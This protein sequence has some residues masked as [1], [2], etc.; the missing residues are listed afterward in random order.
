MAI[1][2]TMTSPQIVHNSSVLFETAW[3][4]FR[5]WLASGWGICSVTCGEGRQ[6]RNIHCWQTLEA[7]FHSSVHSSLCASLV[8]PSSVRS[9]RQIDCGPLWE[10]SEWSQV[11]MERA[12]INYA[13]PLAVL[14][15]YFNT[16]RMSETHP[17]MNNPWSENS[18]KSPNCLCLP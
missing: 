15:E 14:Q 7:G 3:V 12:H 8:L 18:R 4:S 16:C 1:N 13:V 6:F 5:R 11:N 17:I 9:C 10:M 2:Y